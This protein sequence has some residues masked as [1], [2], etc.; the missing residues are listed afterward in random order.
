[1][2][3]L[4][5]SIGVLFISHSMLAMFGTALERFPLHD[6]VCKGFEQLKNAVGA[7]PELINVQLPASMGDFF[8]LKTPLYLAVTKGSEEKAGFL[9]EKG[10]NPNIA[11]AKGSM[12]LH[13]AVSLNRLDLVQLLLAHG[14]TVDQK[15]NLGRLPLDLVASKEMGT[16][17]R[18]HMPVAPA[19][20]PDFPSV[21]T[22]SPLYT[23]SCRIWNMVP[24]KKVIAS[25]TVLALAGY[26]AWRIWRR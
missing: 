16:L 20:R 25:T 15:D 12:P 5:F 17:L 23:L 22:F 9:L 26:A 13:H 19:V 14:A 3:K 8:A 11:A 4:L 7:Y 10:A 6:A 21:F 2:K 18:K 1:M 24:S